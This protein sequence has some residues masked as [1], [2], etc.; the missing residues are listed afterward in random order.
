MFV[1]EVQ[2]EE[3]IIEL[4]WFGCVF[5]GLLMGAR[6]GSGRRVGW[7]G[8]VGEEQALGGASVDVGGHVELTKKN[9]TS[10][11]IDIANL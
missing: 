9:K 4:P 6:D 2:R 5:D 11:K 8:G 7:R 1:S 10:V 3:K